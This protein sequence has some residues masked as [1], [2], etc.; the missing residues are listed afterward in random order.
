MFNGNLVLENYED[1]STL[2]ARR[3]FIVACLL[4]Y[5]NTHIAPY[6]SGTKYSF[7]RKRT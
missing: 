4:F 1:L 7:L 6:K 3:F 5:L 2:C